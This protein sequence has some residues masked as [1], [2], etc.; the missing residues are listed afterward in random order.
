MSDTLPGFLAEVSLG[1]SNVGSG[2]R[3]RLR[4]DQS[5]VRPAQGA[6]C[7][8]RTSSA[9][10]DCWAECIAGCEPNVRECFPVCRAECGGQPRD[11]GTVIGCIPRDNSVNN[12]LCLAGITAW[13]VSA[14]A[15]CA[16]LTGPFAGPC[17][18]GVDSLAANQRASC[19]PPVICT[20]TA[21]P[22]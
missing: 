21:G 11:P 3:S 13:E 2:R 19:P 10:A 20:Q 7:S 6:P 8:D 18:A 4:R 9:C 16:V 15:I 1:P 12:S 17:S 14:K 5:G 22:V